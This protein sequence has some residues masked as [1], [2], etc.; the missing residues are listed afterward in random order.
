[1]KRLMSFMGTFLMVV[2][3][4][5]ALLAG[6][7]ADR[8]NAQK[9]GGTLVLGLE[10]DPGHFNMI[11]KPGTTVEVPGANMYNKLL[12]LDYN[13]NPVPELA[14]K[15]EVSADGK[16]IT[17]HLR[18]G[19][20]FHD[21][22]EMTSEDVK[23]SLDKALPFNPR[24][25]VFWTPVKDRVETP[26]KYTV[27]VYL[28]KPFA[29]MLRIMGVMFGGP[30][31]YPKRHWKVIRLPCRSWPTNGRSARTASGSPSTCA[32]EFSSTTVMR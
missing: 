17:F 8:A 2:F 25:K 9:R 18:K 4:G 12:T 32:R 11:L 23:F 15:W 19:V 6:P 16:R 20:L 7:L 27:V 26:D 31:I 10:A 30:Q 3:L 21:G 13:N 24:S 14:H 1:M 5:S 28:K 29:P 22:Y